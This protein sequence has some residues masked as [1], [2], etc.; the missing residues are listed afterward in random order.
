LA[1]PPVTGKPGK[2]QNPGG[3]VDLEVPGLRF[4]IELQFEKR[5][6]GNSRAALGDAKLSEAS[7]KSIQKPD[8][9]L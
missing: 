4:E 5:N 9:S 7:D 1:E 2:T 3:L 8:L 6:A